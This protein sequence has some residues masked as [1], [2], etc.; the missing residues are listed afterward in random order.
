MRSYR[1]AAP[2]R[3]VGEITDWQ[4]QTPESIRAWREKLK[5]PTGEIIN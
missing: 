5:N 4:K 1:S 3:I 2:L